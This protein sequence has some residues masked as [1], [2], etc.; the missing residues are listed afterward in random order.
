MLLDDGKKGLDPVRVRDDHG[1][2][3]QGPALG[4]AYIKDVAEVRQVTEGQV[5]FRAGQGIAQAGAVQIERDPVFIADFPHLLQVFFRIQGPVFGRVGDIDHA[6]CHHVVPVSVR[7]KV[8]QVCPHNSRIKL[9]VRV[10][11][12]QDLVAA[13]LDCAGLVGRD[14]TRLRRDHPLPGPQQRVDHRRVGLGPADQKLH[15]CPR[16]PAGFPDL[17]P[18][19]FR[20][21]IMPVT[22]R[23]HHVGLREPLQDRG[24]GPFHIVTCKVQFFFHRSGSPFCR[25][26]PATCRFYHI[27]MQT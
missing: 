22:G 7:V 23:L 18:R 20:K 9:S 5:V 13:G 2:P 12:S 6:R 25:F 11:Q 3:E 15:L 17:P 24:V 4:P 10:R 26:L 19:G 1:L 14:V 21:G 8:R 27:R 16:T